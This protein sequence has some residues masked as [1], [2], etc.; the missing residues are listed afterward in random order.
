MN[1]ILLMRTKTSKLLDSIVKIDCF[2]TVNKYY[3]VLCIMESG[4]S[5]IYH[6]VDLL[7]IIADSGDTFLWKLR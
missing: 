6:Y 2:A 5:L 4:I 1:P 3:K 7:K